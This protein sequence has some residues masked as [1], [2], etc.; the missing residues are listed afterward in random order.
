MSSGVTGR[1][2]CLP[3]SWMCS[4][5]SKVCFLCLRGKHFVHWALSTAQ[6]QGV[7]P[8]NS[9]TVATWWENEKDGGKTICTKTEIYQNQL[10]MCF[11]LAKASDSGSFIVWFFLCQQKMKTS[12]SHAKPTWSCSACSRKWSWSFSP[13]VFTTFSLVTETRSHLL[14][15]K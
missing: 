8:S 13:S 15:T 10:F 5:R 14:D 7:N 1:A 2:P 4:Q 6:G 12:H 9:G 3:D 11:L